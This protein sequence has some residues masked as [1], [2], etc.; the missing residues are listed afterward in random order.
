MNKVLITGISGQDGSYLAEQLLEKGY[1][2]HG[3]IRRASHFNT[4]RI[5][6]IY[7][8]IHL[9]YGDVT[10]GNSIN[11]LISK[12]QPQYIFNMSAQ[13]HVKTSFEIP[14]YTS[15]V[16]AIGTLN[17]L[18]AVRNHSPESKILQ[19]STSELYGKVQETPQNEQTPFYPRSP[20][21]VAKLYAYWI[22]KNYREAYDIFG[23]NS[24][25]FNHEGPRRGITFV[26][27]KITTSL[28][29]IKHGQRKILKLGN[30]DAKRDWGYAKEYCAAMIKML[31]QEKPDDYV[32]ATGENHTI[33]EFVE[34]SAAFLGMDIV[35]EG[36][37]LN[38]KGIDTKTGKVIIE[39]DPNYYRPAEVETLLGDATYAKQ[40][41]GWEPMTKFEALVELMT[42]NDRDYFLMNKGAN[43]TNFHWDNYFLYGI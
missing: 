11:T 14:L 42:L 22:I 38:E 32:I 15:Q 40:K 13:S 23:V 27:R 6:H 41:M 9:H 5:D 30:L 18:E 8:R 34:L 25:C 2:V 26:T 19:A 31:E 28:V 10:D 12:L 21:G 33:R 20:Y 35:W 16:D 43:I 24:I 7:D 37:G 17:V 1:E 39:I 3:I 36:E 29:E 4:Q